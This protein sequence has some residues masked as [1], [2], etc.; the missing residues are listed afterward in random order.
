MIAH[1]LEIAVVL[2]PALL[3]E[4]AAR[5]PLQA[6]DGLLE[7]AGQGVDAAEIIEEHRVVGVDA[8]GAAGPVEALLLLAQGDEA[9]G[10]HVEGP[11][12]V[13]VEVDALLDERHAAPPGGP[14]V[15][16]SSELLIDLGDE[17]RRV[18]VLRPDPH[19]LF[20]ERSRL[21]HIAGREGL[22]GIEI[23]RFEQ[24]RVEP[25]GPLEARLRLLL[26]A[27][28]REGDGQGSLGL[29][30]FGGE[31]D[32]PA[33]GRLSLKTDRVLPLRIE[34][35]VGPA[36]GQTGM[37]Q[38][39]GGVELDRPRKELEG[40]FDVVAPVAVVKAPAPQVIVVSLDVARRDLGQGALLLRAE[41]DPQGADD[42]AGD[43][44][45]DG[46]D[47]AELPVI[48]F[49][50]EVEAAGGL[51]ELDRDPEPVLGLPDAALENVVDAEGVADL[52]ETGGRIL[53]LERA[54]AGG[55]PEALNA[56]E[57]VDD[58]LGYAVAEIPL[59]LF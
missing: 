1:G 49:G 9:V 14:G 45:L 34:I 35:D 59:V 12:V 52:A 21:G 57:G 7:G 50:P 39:V 18:E 27:A 15:L 8:P 16:R 29:G 56:A 6:V 30:A 41:R 46:E 42:V 17:E 55:D 47:V 10:A 28:E 31:L 44:L 53:E 40:E 11:D 24:R 25:D 51:D 54:G 32:G 22:T 20:I 58:L 4:S 5:G 48:G 38:G 3:E 2:V 19:G 13:G 23:P 43:L 33:A 26:A 36:V 37:G